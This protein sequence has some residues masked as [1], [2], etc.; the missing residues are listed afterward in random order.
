MG[1]FSGYD[2]PLWYA[3]G[4][5]EEHLAVLTRAGLFDTSHMAGVIVS[6]PDARVFLN[7]MFTKDL[8]RCLGLKTKPLVPGRCAYGAF[9]DENG[10]VVDDSI[11]FQL[12]DD[13]IWF[14]S[15]QAWAKPSQGTSGRIKKT[16][17]FKLNDWTDKIGK[18]DLQGPLAAK[19]LKKVIKN[20]DNV[21]AGYD[22][23]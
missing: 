4:V 17:M 5:K 12:T 16:M 21:L 23:F 22:L 9:L 18:I 3:T 10:H 20:P 15:M 13:S 14:M 8:S 11:I 19:V 1:V 6:G 2:M 7:W